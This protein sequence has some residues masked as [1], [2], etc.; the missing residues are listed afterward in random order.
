MEKKLA[1]FVV[2]ILIVLIF[3]GGYFVGFKIG[4]DKMFHSQIRLPI[5]N[6]LYFDDEQIETRDGSPILEYSDNFCFIDKTNDP[7][8]PLKYS[9]EEMIMDNY[10]YIEQECL[11][12]VS[13]RLI[14]TIVPK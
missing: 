9:C 3:T 8:R 14:Q 13:E 10:K 6:K 1:F 12:K 11:K 2:I 7:Q 5:V 4:Y